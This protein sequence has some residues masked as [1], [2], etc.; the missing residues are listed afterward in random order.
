MHKLKQ[1]TVNLAYLYLNWQFL[2]FTMFL[3]LMCVCMLLDPS[4]VQLVNI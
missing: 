2:S 1:L 4:H 3:L